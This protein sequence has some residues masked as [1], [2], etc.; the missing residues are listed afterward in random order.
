MSE[1][2]NGGDDPVDLKYHFNHFSLRKQRLHAD[3]LGF[4]MKSVLWQRNNRLKGR[5]RCGNV[6]CEQKQLT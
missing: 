2:T 3:I 6:S 1:R 4:V 5:I